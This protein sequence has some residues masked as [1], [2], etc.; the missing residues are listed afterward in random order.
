MLKAPPPAKF[1]VRLTPLRPLAKLDLRAEGAMVARFGEALGVPLPTAPLTS[2]IA[3]EVT[4]L[5]LGPD[6]WLCLGGDC[7]SALEAALAGGFGAVTDVGQHWVGYELA[8]PAVR[9]VLAAGCRLDLHPSA[10]PVGFASTT[11]VG[12]A[13]TILHRRADV[14]AAPVFWAFVRRSFAPYLERWLAVT[15]REFGLGA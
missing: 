3:G 8:G 11:L 6:R 12:K 7:R 14:A 15:G 10:V 9:D 2:A 4:V 1:G 5:W 13:E